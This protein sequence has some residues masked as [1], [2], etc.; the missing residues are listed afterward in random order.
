MSRTRKTAPK[1]KAVPPCKQFTQTK[2]ELT[3]R[4]DHPEN[5]DEYVEF[6]VN[7]EGV[8]YEDETNEARMP[9]AAMEA[10]AKWYLGIAK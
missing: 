6:S 3:F 10:F 5:S 9:L 2:P 4:W 8:S 1:Q 7:S